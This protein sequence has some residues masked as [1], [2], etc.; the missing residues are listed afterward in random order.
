MKK[1][2]MSAMAGAMMFVAG[3]ANATLPASFVLEDTQKRINQMVQIMNTYQSTFDIP[4]PVYNDD[5]IWMNAGVIGY[6]VAAIATIN[7]QQKADIAELEEDLIELEAALNGANDDIEAMQAQIDYLNKVV[8]QN[9]DY[10]EKM[11]KLWN[12]EKAAHKITKGELAE[13][14]EGYQY[15]KKQFGLVNKLSVE[16]AYEIIELNATI[17]SLNADIAAF[18]DGS[19]YVG[20]TYAS[21]DATI[22]AAVEASKNLANEYKIV[23]VSGTKFKHYVDGKWKTVNASKKSSRMVLANTIAYHAEAGSL[24]KIK[25]VI[26]VKTAAAGGWQTTHGSATSI[27]ASL[28]INEIAQIAGYAEAKVTQGQLRFNKS[29]VSFNAT[30][31]GATELKEFI[32]D[33]AE[34]VYEDGYADGYADGYED[35]YRDG[36][37]D[38]L[39]GNDY[40]G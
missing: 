15:Y 11:N 37:A 20:Y 29:G 17:A 19:A 33:L 16:Q 2:I 30:S 3:T 10:G 26:L 14:T 4:E 23:K 31:A 38:A 24:M 6:W 36:W 5:G 32:E 9:F 39:A 28:S 25:S 21:L 40:A 1:L 27:T 22:D 12:E 35:G 34:E 18:E 7:E 8:D 13:M